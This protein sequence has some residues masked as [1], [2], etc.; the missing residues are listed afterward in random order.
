MLEAVRSTLQ[1][2]K[3]GGGRGMVFPYAM[4]K[5][6]SQGDFTSSFKGSWRTANSMQS[7]PKLS[8]GVSG[9]VGVTSDLHSSFMLEFKTPLDLGAKHIR[10]FY[11]SLGAAYRVTVSSGDQGQ[12]AIANSDSEDHVHSIAFML[13]NVS[14]IIQFEISQIGSAKGEFELH[15]ISIENTNTGLVYHN[16]GVGGA[17]YQALLQERFFED[18]IEMLKPDVVVLDWGTND[19]I[20]KNSISEDQATIIVKTIGRV[21]RALPHAV[22]ILTT[23]QDMNFKGNN[24]TVARQYSELI[25]RIALENRC[26]FYDW[27]GVSGGA[28][29]MEEW[30]SRGLALND[31]VHLNMAGYKV[32]GM[33]FAQAFLNTLNYY[34]RYGT[35]KT[36]SK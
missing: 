16:L 17:A 22:I 3:R 31:N 32:K 15:G 28:G 1:N 14:N 12:S 6:Y 21:R 9:F 13:K 11:R 7:P 18:E 23:P 20:Y 4:A 30:Y 10:L 27:Y 8:L 19:I 34:N 2:Y 26:L 25:R 29:S 36:A 33:L 35:T 24:I 5:T